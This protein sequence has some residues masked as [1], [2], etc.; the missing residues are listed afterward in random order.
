MNDM[1]VKEELL[2]L[3]FSTMKLLNTKWPVS[4]LKMFTSFN[5]SIKQIS[6]KALKAEPRE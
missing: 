4:W 2:S 6:L 5:Q 1:V 3:Q